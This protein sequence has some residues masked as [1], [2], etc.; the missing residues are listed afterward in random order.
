MRGCF[1]FSLRE[2]G[3]S[4]GDAPDVGRL[5]HVVDKAYQYRTNN[6]ADTILFR[7]IARCRP[8]LEGKNLL[9]RGQYLFGRIFNVF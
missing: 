6:A 8:L 7:Y 5:A 4:D 9:F 3:R 2:V 1:V